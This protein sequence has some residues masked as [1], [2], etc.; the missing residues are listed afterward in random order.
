MGLKGT[1]GPP[2][3]LS[4]KE[5]FTE[6]KAAT[7]AAWGT[8]VTLM[9][10]LACSRAG[11]GR[12]NSYHLQPAPQ[13]QRNAS[14]EPLQSSGAKSPV[15]MDDLKGVCCS[16]NSRK[17]E[18]NGKDNRSYEKALQEFCLLIKKKKKEPMEWLSV[19]KQLQSFIWFI[20][21]YEEES[22]K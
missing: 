12:P 4:A 9:P 8:F 2:P 19:F 11:K 7:L 5:A 15:E 16:G 10:A 13:S 3:R 1:S 17:G 18:Q 14:P 6:R 21:F 20:C 22:E